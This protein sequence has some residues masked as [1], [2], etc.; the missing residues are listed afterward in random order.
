M[1]WKSPDTICA[2]FLVLQDFAVKWVRSM[3]ERYH[4]LTAADD[5][6][7]TEIRIDDAK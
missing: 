1:M 2:L 5:G 3:P 7:V 6:L 4:T